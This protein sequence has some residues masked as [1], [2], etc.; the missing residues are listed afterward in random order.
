V[1]DVPEGAVRIPL[2]TRDGSLRAYTLVDAA[3]A[4]WV[5]QWR[6]FASKPGNDGRVYAIR[7]EGPHG[8]AK[9]VVL[10]R[11]LLG[12]RPEQ[13]GQ[14]VQHVNGDWLDCRRA[15][16]TVGPPG[17]GRTG[18]VP[19]VWHGGTPRGYSAIRALAGQLGRR[20]Y[21]LVVLTP[22]LDPFY[23]GSPAQQQTAAWFAEHWGRCQ[24]PNG[25]HLRRI[26]YRLVSDRVKQPD[27][28]AIR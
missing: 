13:R 9:A 17:R 7:H 15:N 8:T 22:K 28:T 19:A 12:L 21:D 14:Q 24:F 2:Y 10:R 26:H 6:W 23:T 1:E 25:V 5:N 11:A 27:G 20:V 18:S 4:D 3:D 16:L